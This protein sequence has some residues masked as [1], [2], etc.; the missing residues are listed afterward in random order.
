MTEWTGAAGRRVV[1][2]GGTGGIGLAA[3]AELA[4]RGAAITVVGHDEERATAAVARIAESAPEAPPAEAA[5]ADLRLQ[6]EVRR[7]AADL[8]RRYAVIDVLV[9]NAGA[10]FAR[11]Q[12]T[13][14]GYEATWALNHL[15]PFLLTALLVDRMKRHPPA[16]IVTTAS[17]AH[18]PAHIPFDD[19]GAERSYR[20]HGYARYGE[21]KLAN[22]L[23]TAQ[24]AHFLEGSGVTANCFHPGLVATGFNM[25]NGPLMTLSMRAIRPFSRSPEQGADTLVWLVESPEVADENGGYFVDRR[26]VLPS[27][28]AQDM[29]AAGRLWELSRRQTSDPRADPLTS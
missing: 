21:T 23:F 3:A 13:A 6:T 22:I 10:M 27:A 24:L 25:G 19:V 20:N 7:L 28:A 2:T 4:R 11:R 29:E 8:Q 15:A 1:I 26:R 18:Q 17:A 16:R 9:N 5:V 12:V 14:E